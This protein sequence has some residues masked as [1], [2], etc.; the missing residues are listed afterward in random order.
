MGEMLWADTDEWRRRER[1]MGNINK[2]INKLINKVD[3]ST[4]IPL[5]IRIIRM[6]NDEEIFQFKI[7]LMSFIEKWTE[8]MINSISTS[9][10]GVLDFFFTSNCKF[11][12]VFFININVYI[13]NSQLDTMLISHRTRNN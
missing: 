7:K 4:F 12:I 2:K 5:Q 3:I 1:L 6:M 13:Y 11:H 9:L 10:S 8:M